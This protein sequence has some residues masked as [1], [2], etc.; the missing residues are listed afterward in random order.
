MFVYLNRQTMRGWFALSWSI[1][2]GNGVW[3]PVYKKD[4]GLTGG[5]STGE[6]Y[7]GR[8]QGLDYLYERLRL[9][10]NM[11]LLIKG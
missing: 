7:S 8:M 5:E 3:N 11:L 4:V 2:Y 10:I 9:I 6:T 1:I